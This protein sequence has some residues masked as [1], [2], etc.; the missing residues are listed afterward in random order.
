MKYFDVIGFIDDV[1]ESLYGSFDRLDCKYELEAEKTSWKD[2]GYKGIQIVSRETSD[3]P[4]P[5]VYENLVSF[6][7]VNAIIESKNDG[8]L[9]DYIEDKLIT[10]TGEQFFINDEQ[11]LSEIKM[12]VID[13][14]N[15]NDDQIIEIL[16]NSN[17]EYKFFAFDLYAI[18]R[19]QSG[20]LQFVKL[21]NKN[22]NDINTII[23]GI[24]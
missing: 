6:N 1:S 18:Y 12:N 9:H 21:S 23:R 8:E 7:D 24:K 14:N 4:D 10:K 22:R 19:D 16:K 17:I 5:T 3:K 20:N 15:L 11:L 2:Q 13:N